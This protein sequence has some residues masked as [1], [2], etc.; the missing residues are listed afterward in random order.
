MDQSLLL[1]LISGFS[2]AV[3]IYFSISIPRTII[4]GIASGKYGED[5]RKMIAFMKVLGYVEILCGVVLFV[6]ETFVGV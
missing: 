1:Y 4:Q 5:K 6:I 3:G 2:I